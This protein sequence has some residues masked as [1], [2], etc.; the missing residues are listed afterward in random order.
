VETLRF[1]FDIGTNGERVAVRGSRAATRDCHSPD[2]PKIADRINHISRRH[3]GGFGDVS[4]ARPA[5]SGFVRAVLSLRPEA[6]ALGVSSATAWLY[7]ATV[8]LTFRR[9]D[10][11]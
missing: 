8:N 5:A 9:L 1:T 2:E 6:P 10:S 3:A 4:H 11:G 7:I